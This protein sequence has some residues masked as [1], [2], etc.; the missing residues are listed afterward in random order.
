MTKS[1]GNE[2]L[3][4][5]KKLF[6]KSEAQNRMSLSTVKMIL[7]DIDT[8]YKEFRT[9]EGL[10]ALFFHPSSPDQSQYMTIKDI[11]SDIAIAEEVMDKDLTEFLKKLII[12]VE[13]EEENDKPI[14]VMISHTGMAV[15]VLDLNSAEEML[16][17]T[18]DAISS[19]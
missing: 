12:I 1:T 14:V 13:K 17:K 9:A 2:A 16:D 10:G 6:G 4:L 3:Q 15:H 19:D 18:A 5:A 8:L 7:G 11:Q